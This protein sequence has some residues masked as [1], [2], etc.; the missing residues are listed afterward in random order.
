MPPAN[1]AQ[2]EPANHSPLP[3][4][5]EQSPTIP[6]AIRRTRRKIRP[7]TEWWKVRHPTPAV[8]SDSEDSDIES[9]EDSAEFVTRCICESVQNVTARLCEAKTQ[10]QTARV[11]SKQ[12]RSAIFGLWVEY[13]CE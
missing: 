3:D 5:R 6:I 11:R 4:S 13:V 12:L 2:I 7:P 9:D 10:Y 1:P 8:G